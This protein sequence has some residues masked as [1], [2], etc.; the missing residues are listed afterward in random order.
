MDE[1]TQDQFRCYITERI[2]AHRKRHGL[3]RCSCDLSPPLLSAD[4][5][6]SLEEIGLLI[7]KLREA[8]MASKRM[9]DLTVDSAYHFRPLRSHSLT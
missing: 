8:L 5:K 3:L 1:G 6:S 2:R 4:L 7:R 9:G